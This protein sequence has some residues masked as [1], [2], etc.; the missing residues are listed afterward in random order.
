MKINQFARMDAPFSQKVDEL[1]KINF[2]P[3]QADF[4][5]LN[6]LYLYFLEKVLFEASSQA[7]L[8]QKL[9][10][11][12]ATSTE[13]LY[14]YLAHKEINLT[15]FYAI[16]MQLLGFEVDDDFDI[17]DPLKKMDEIHLYHHDAL[18]DEKD[19]INA[20][21]DLLCT[22]N[23]DGRTL[24][25]SLAANGYF[26]QFWGLDVNKKPLIFNGKTQ[27][28]FD[29][30][31]LIREVVYVESSL[32]TDHDGK[33]D[34]LKAEIIRPV[35]TELGLK[36]PVL[37][38]ASPYNEGTNDKTTDKITHN[39][40]VPLKRKEPNNTTYEEIEFKYENSNLPAAR[41]VNGT[42]RAAE[43]TFG[44]D[45]NVTINDY[46]LARGFAVVYAAGIGTKDSDGERTCGSKEETLS[47]TAII[48]WL[49]GNRKAFTNKTDNIEI[50]AWWCNGSV[51]MTGK[52]YLGTLATAAA[53][54][55][56]KGLK[57]I[58]SE[59]AISS[60]YDYYRDGGLVI[61]PGGYP[62][63]DA[64]VLA[65]ECFSRQKQA[66]DYLKIKTQFNQD[67]AQI[68]K[69]Q[70]R[71]SG[72]YNS[73]WDAR[74]YLKD[75]P[76]IKCDVVMVHGL[77]DWNVKPRNVFNLYKELDKLPIK[78]KLF[79]HQ[80]Q[81]IYINNFQ[82]ID[83]TDMMNLWLTN[84]LYGVENH[85]NELIP[86]VCVQD[87]STEGTWHAFDGW[88]TENPQTYAYKFQTNA[89]SLDESSPDTV[90]FSDQ[91][92]V[93]DFNLY[94]KNW[95]KWRQDLLSEKENALTGNHLIF[96]TNKFEKDIYLQGCPHLK[97]KVASNQ[98]KGML[99]FMLVDFGNIKRLGEVPSTLALKALD[100]GF[101]WKED[102]LKE[103]KLTA[104]T[105]W[106]MITKGHINL[107]NRENNWKNS[108][109]K[110]NQFYDIDLDLQPMFYH[111]VKGNQLGL[112]IYS[113]D[114][115]MTVRGNENL[116]Y[117]VQLENCQLDL[118]YETL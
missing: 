98:D 9:H 5:P 107:Q 4:L 36:V 90:T 91:L 76:N 57:T 70:D 32:D 86:D 111:L 85:A 58:I 53:T 1:R 81:H 39:V 49:A 75:V 25:D 84:K 24:L 29:T 48:E 19:L 11:F 109:V 92:K 23:K 68:T 101:Q 30:S 78:K 83:F 22:H 64:D 15:V 14:D 50:K 27:P 97:L 41:K 52:S 38:T 102:D 40:D 59:A 74:N 100:A 7:T 72:N 37:Y 13:D 46:F 34:L 117:S 21:Y 54:T 71:D 56:V 112:V 118:N 51:A 20:W 3:E 67:L 18:N 82:S 94:K 79:L 110:A 12:L 63:E 10:G 28:V 108:E 35:D 61:A 87:N 69:D 8:A 31:K 104:P 66:G 96:K 33:R 105:P 115:E 6:E 65:E 62:G 116:S 113:T 103:F 47:T 77:N 42:S 43:E 106:K 26:K 88:Q 16:A 89:L 114:M 45:H 73:F 99:S 93:E 55:G 44:H 17:N 60:W 2:Y 95:D 80:G